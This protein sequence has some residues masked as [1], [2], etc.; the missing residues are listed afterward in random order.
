MASHT[1]NEGT[2]VHHHPDLDMLNWPVLGISIALWPFLGQLWAYIPGPTAFYMIVSAAFML[3]QMSDKLGLLERFK[4]RP[5]L[6]APPDQPPE[7]K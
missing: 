2:E 7:E 4:R 5:M 1:Q 3:F 6:A